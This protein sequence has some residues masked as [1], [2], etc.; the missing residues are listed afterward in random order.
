MSDLRWLDQVAADAAITAAGFRLAFAIARLCRGSAVVTQADLAAT[1][2]LKER[3]VR[4]AIAALRDRGHLAVTSDCGWTSD[5]RPVLKPRHADAGAT[6]PVPRDPA[7]QH[8]GT[9]MPG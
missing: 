4:N 8:P 5:Y 2:R 1:A 6:L 3:A 9:M 7:T